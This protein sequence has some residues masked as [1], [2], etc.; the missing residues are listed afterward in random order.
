MDRYWAEIADAV[1]LIES[2]AED[3]SFPN[4]SLAAAVASKCFFHLEE[5][6][7][8]LRLAMGAEKYFDVNS[9]SQYIETLLA[10]CIDEYIALRNQDDKSTAMAIDPRM[11][12]I[13]EGLFTRCYQDQTFAQ[14]MG[15]ALESRRLDKIREVFD[16]AKQVSSTSI[17]ELLT[18]T[19]HVCRSILSNRDFRLKVLEEM[20]L[21]RLTRV[22]VISRAG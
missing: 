22:Y 20:V 21:V 14:A 12:A 3:E 4:R 7:D 11:D 8:A 2:L 15:I 16:Q 5:Y 1:P 17:S 10:T 19:F 18:Y 9:K 6:S 13:V